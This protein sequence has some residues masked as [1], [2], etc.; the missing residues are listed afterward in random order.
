MVLLRYWFFLLPKTKVLSYMR[1]LIYH[2]T[3]C[4]FKSPLGVWGLA[5]L[6]PLWGF[7]GFASAQ[8]NLVP[9]P[10]FEILSSCPTSTGQITLATG[11]FAP[12]YTYADVFNTCAALS[13]VG[14]PLND[15]LTGG[16]SASFKY[17][18]DGNG[19]AGIITYQGQYGFNIPWLERGYLEARLNQ[20]LIIGK[21]YYICFFVSPGNT[22]CTLDSAPCYTDAIGLALTQQ[23]IDSVVNH[24]HIN[25]Q[26][27]LGLKPAI[28]HRGSIL[29]DT[30]VWY[31]IS[32]GYRGNGENYVIIGNFETDANTIGSNF[33]YSNYC[34]PMLSFDYIDEVGIYEYDP[35]PDTI[36]LCTGQNVRLGHSFL[37]ATYL[38]STG[39]TDSVIVVD[40]P[41]KYIINTGI[42]GCQLSDTVLIIDPA[43]GM[44]DMPHDTT[45]CLPLILSVP[46]PGSYTWSDSSHA[47]T[48]SISTTGEYG[49]TVTNV[50]G[51]YSRSIEVT[52]RPCDCHVYMPNAFSPNDDGIND[53]LQPFVAC[54]F[55]IYSVRCII[56]DRWGEIVYENDSPDIDN[57]KW[58]GS[59]RGKMLE[60]GIYIILWEYCYMEDGT[61]HCTT[62][63][64]SIT[65]IR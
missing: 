35:L 3:S 55:P 53:T 40:K 17:P 36:L 27:P 14:V 44:A 33:C 59:Y 58:D 22:N 11:W 7:G 65:F 49:V 38:W 8:T 60:S 51:V 18:K 28:E 63:K 25:Y 21:Q 57:V 15:P 64:G 19:Y 30:S 52:G 54:D 61:S 16:G 47:D 29:N 42:G 62:K 26:E 6:S 34:G 13:K 4:L 37:D 12:T 50:C 23:L 48:I 24:I 1:K 39:S 2:I 43:A 45:A 10:S 31:Q 5:F 56:A 20:T 46:I 41:G 9:N 32:G